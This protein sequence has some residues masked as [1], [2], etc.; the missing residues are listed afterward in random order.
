MLV[1][2]HVIMNIVWDEHAMG[3]GFVTRPVSKGSDIIG[4]R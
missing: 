1:L 2:Y 4:L 3:N